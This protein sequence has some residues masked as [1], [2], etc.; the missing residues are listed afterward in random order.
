M[1]KKSFIIFRYFS[2]VK[3]TYQFAYEHTLGKLSGKIN[4][5]HLLGHDYKWSY[6]KIRERTKKNISIA[7]RPSTKGICLS[8]ICHLLTSF[9]K[10]FISPPVTCMELG[11]ERT[12]KP[13]RIARSVEKSKHC[14]TSFEG[15]A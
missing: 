2:K 8:Y 3:T 10:I 13:R 1:N 5:I 14:T 7:V 9:S 6:G 12:P 4:I 11:R 15:G